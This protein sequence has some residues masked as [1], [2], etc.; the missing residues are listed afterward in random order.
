MLHTNKMEGSISTIEPSIFTYSA[1]QLIFCLRPIFA[2]LGRQ[3]VKIRTALTFLFFLCR[4]FLC[5]F[6][7]LRHY[8]ITSFWLIKSFLVTL[9]SQCYSLLET[10]VKHIIRNANN[11][12]HIFY[13]PN[14]CKY[15][16]KFFPLNILHNFTYCL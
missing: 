14:V 3:P 2:G 11:L 6:F 12:L 15:F 4:F 10:C 1:A 7:L 8:L 9:T 5:C 13:R 16:I